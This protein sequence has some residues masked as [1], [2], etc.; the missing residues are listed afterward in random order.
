M[1]RLFL[2][3]KLTVMKARFDAG[4]SRWKPLPYLWDWGSE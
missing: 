3:V 2:T 4:L 1:R